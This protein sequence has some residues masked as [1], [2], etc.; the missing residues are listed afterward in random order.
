M[1]LKEM[2]NSFKLERVRL[3]AGMA[4]VELS[5][6]QADRNAAWD[7]YVEMLTRIVT[8]H[9]PLESGD[10]QAALE[11]VHTLFDTTRQILHTHG[12]DTI[13]FSKIA[14]PVLN[15][16]VRPFTTK[17]HRESLSGTFGDKDKSVQFR[18]ELEEL[19]HDMRRYNRMLADIAKVEDLTD[20]EK[21]GENR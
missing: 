12:R 2:F 21:S 14:I 9:L 6:Q 4:S 15:Q 20:L 10:E 19:L 17:W 3:H 18:K 5:F 16:I 1:N 8:Q 11:S 7:L 13:E